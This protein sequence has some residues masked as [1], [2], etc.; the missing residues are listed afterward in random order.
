V[1]CLEQRMQVSRPVQMASMPLP[2]LCC[3]QA[4]RL[5]TQAAF[6]QIVGADDRLESPQ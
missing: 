6:W 2:W 5:S 3:N 4:E 1:A